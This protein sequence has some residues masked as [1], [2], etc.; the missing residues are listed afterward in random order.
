MKPLAARKIKHAVRRIPVCAAAR[1]H[2]T[3]GVNQRIDPQYPDPPRRGD[4]NQ[5]ILEPWCHR[6]SG[7]PLRVDLHRMLEPGHSPD[8]Q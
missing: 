5:L 2:R 7:A 4:V 1:K 3:I 8:R 6:V